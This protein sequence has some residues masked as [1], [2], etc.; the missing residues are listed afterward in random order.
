M[1]CKG[2]VACGIAATMMLLGS[3]SPASARQTIPQPTLTPDAKDPVPA[4]QIQLPPVPDAAIK[5]YGRVEGAVRSMDPA[6]IADLVERQGHLA[7]SFVTLRLDG[8]VVGRGADVADDGRTL[9]RAVEVALQEASAR[10]PKLND[11]TAARQKSGFAADLAISLELSGDLVPFQP[12][13]F[14][15]IDLEVGRG[16]EG[17]AARF[18]TKVRAVSP[19]SM[20]SNLTSPGDA[21]VVAISEASGDPTLA[22][23]SNPKGQPPQ[24]ASE[25]RAVFYK[26]A[27]THLAQL[28]ATQP[29]TFLFRGAKVVS[30]R[31]INTASLRLFAD[32]MAD[33]LIRWD[34]SHRESP[35]WPLG[36]FVPARGTFESK[37]ASLAEYALVTFAI[38]RLIAVKA[39]FQDD[40]S[41]VWKWVRPGTMELA[42]IRFG[43]GRLNQEPL[44][45][46]VAGPLFGCMRALVAMA[47]YEHQPT[48]TGIVPAELMPFEADLASAY[49]VKDGW[50]P[51]IPE[52]TRAFVAFVLAR[53]A[54]LVAGELDGPRRKE[55]AA[56]AVRSLYRETKPAMLVMH[57]PWLGWAEQRMAEGGEIP[58]AA[59][60]R[61]MRDMVWKFQMTAAD[62]G[63]EGPDLIGG[64]VFTSSSEL[65][66]TSQSLRPMAFLASMLGDSRLTDPAERPMQ[67]SRMLAAL[68][69]V[70]QLA[71][72]HD[73]TFNVADPG[74][75]LW[76][77]RASAWDNRQ[78]PE[79]TAL[80][81][82]TVCDSLESLELMRRSNAP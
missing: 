21:M 28:S 49:T 67:V 23:R 10:L 62:A 18:G 74:A 13:T 31:A 53:R 81:L 30:D 5:L 54:T 76:G 2:N 52:N 32:S 22:V 38:H 19:A 43:P 72:D 29:P 15:R 58:A 59:A 14:A 1:W 71:L 25:H 42:K 41:N 46:E 34:G 73:A 37:P 78:T 8:R 40:P 33:W 56:L 11:A 55:L 80:G 36:A 45:G 16:T 75:A 39:K 17:V 24:I 82:L 48:V 60:L 7:A 20:L 6:L 44:G 12:E 3:A 65:L 69:F 26:F 64:I 50:N 77:I 66:P 68:R 61:D 35:D 9:A 51:R 57:M 4:G 47:P 79:A 70:R 63:A 27:A